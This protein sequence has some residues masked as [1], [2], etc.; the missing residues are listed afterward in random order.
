M[1]Q[2][3]LLI[4]R[5]V[6]ESAFDESWPVFLKHV[7]N[8]PGLIRETAGLVEDVVYGK[9]SIRRIY[10]FSFPD[11][12]ALYQALSSEPGEKA[13]ETIHKLTGGQITILIT[14]HREDQLE[15]IRTYRSETGHA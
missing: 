3:V 1:Y 2:L 14:H 7:E 6:D 10:T 5:E 15:N 9:D 8:M 11:K 4:P 12:E 13:G